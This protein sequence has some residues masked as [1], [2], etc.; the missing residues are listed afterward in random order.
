MVRRWLTERI[1]HL[2]GRVVAGMPADRRDWGEAVVAEFAA[3]PPAERRLRWALGGLWFVLRQRATDPAVSPPL[4]WVSRIAV[5]LGV[6]CVLPW[7]LFSALA[8]SETDAP[9]ATLRSMIGLLAAQVVLIVAFVATLWPWRLGRALL[10]AAL[11]AYA[12]AAAF[13][14]A[15]NHGSPLLAVLLFPVPPA[16]AAAPILIVGSLTRRPG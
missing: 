6:V 12:A 8:I 5:V 7:A 16:M 1:E 11:A 3:I 10:V 14:A 9:D 4:R 15:D 13:A 2:V